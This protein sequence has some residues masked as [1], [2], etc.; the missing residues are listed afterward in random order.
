MR[1]RKIFVVVAL[2]LVVG[3][4]GCTQGAEGDG[5]QAGAGRKEVWFRQR[6]RL[7]GRIFP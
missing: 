2:S 1:N 3:L 7:W 5:P 4:V 6:Q